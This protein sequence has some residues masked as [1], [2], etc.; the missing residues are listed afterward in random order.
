MLK[1]LQIW[2][3][4]ETIKAYIKLQNTNNF[5]IYRLQLLHVGNLPFTLYLNM[6]NKIW[7]A[8]LHAVEYKL[9]PSIVSYMEHIWLNMDFISKM[10]HLR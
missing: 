7:R 1:A 5:I 9:K 6:K 4:S 10:I 8:F 2:F 3:F